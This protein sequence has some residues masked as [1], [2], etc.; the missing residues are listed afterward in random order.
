MKKLLSVFLSIA[1]I[2]TL[3]VP[4]FAANGENR[5]EDPQVVESY[6]ADNKLVTIF[7]DDLVTMERYSVK[8]GELVVSVL[9]KRDSDYITVI[10][11]EVQ[12]TMFIASPASSG[13]TTAPRGPSLSNST[14]MG[15]SYRVSYG[16]HNSWSLSCPQYDNGGETIFSFACTERESF[17][18]NLDSFRTDVDNIAAL[19]QKI[20]IREGERI[21]NIAITAAFAVAPSPEG[22]AFALSAWFAGR[23]YS[24]DIQDFAA[25][26]GVYQ[27]D[28]YDKYWR[29]QKEWSDLARKLP[30][31]DAA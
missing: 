14:E 18:E 15:Y 2:S 23:N 25:E 29:V 26:I 11:G 6:Y 21:L 10:R 7:E 5:E 30:E 24:T 20:A 9:W 16:S 17:Y 22:F 13:L 12:N 1:M 19:E 8:T 31:P 27:K 28:A 4:A 3:C